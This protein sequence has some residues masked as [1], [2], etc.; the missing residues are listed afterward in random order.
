MILTTPFGKKEGCAALT[1]RSYDK[2][3][4][5][6]NLFNSFRSAQFSYHSFCRTS[7]TQTEKY[8]NKGGVNKL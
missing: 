4:S 6:E 8:L 1:K 2:G 5:A 7:L 3:G